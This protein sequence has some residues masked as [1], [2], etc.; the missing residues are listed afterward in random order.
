MLGLAVELGQFRA[1]VC[2]HVP[3]DLLHALQVGGAGRLGT[4]A[5]C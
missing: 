2:G 5:L 3:H 4:G 1:E